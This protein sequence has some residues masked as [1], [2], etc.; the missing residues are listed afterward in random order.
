MESWFI[1]DREHLGHNVL[2]AIGPTDWLEITT[3]FVHGSGYHGADIGYTITGPLFQLKTL[4]HEAKPNA[5][6]GLAFAAGVLSPFGSGLLTPKGVNTFGYMALTQALF[7]NDL[8]LHA[9]LGVATAD[10]K[11]H[12]MVT[13]ITG[14]GFQAQAI[15]GLHAVGEVHYG[16]PYDPI[17]PTGETQ[18]G[19][20]YFVNDNL[21]FDGTVGRH[22]ENNYNY[23]QWWTLGIRI[24]S[25]PLW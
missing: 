11:T 22:I 1:S 20:R 2:G 5:L 18:I 19:F 7:N 21:Q 24:V 9:N 12:L 14:F 6:P 13:P 8:L 10:K 15:A 17:S 16:D 23:D 4:V 3:G 25:P